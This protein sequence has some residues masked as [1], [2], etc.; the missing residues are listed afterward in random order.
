MAHGE[1]CCKTEETNIPPLHKNSVT[2]RYC[3]RIRRNQADLVVPHT[4]AMVDCSRV[5]YMYT[6]GVSLLP[7]Q[8]AIQ[9]YRG[10]RCGSLLEYISVPRLVGVTVVYAQDVQSLLACL[11]R[12]W[13][14]QYLD[15]C[16]N[17]SNSSLREA[18]AVLSCDDQSKPSNSSARLRSNIS[19]RDSTQYS[20]SDDRGSSLPRSQSPSSPSHASS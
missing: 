19:M 10:I 13:F 9:Q 12:T 8:A 18:R 1:E 16:M 20:Y 11:R 7:H 14:A 3:R 5:H 15:D 17:Q 4:E 6:S 2:C